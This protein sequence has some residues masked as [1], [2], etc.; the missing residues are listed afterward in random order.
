MSLSIGYR[1]LF[2]VVAGVMISSC[3][4]PIPSNDVQVAEEPSAQPV[5]MQCFELMGSGPTAPDQW[6]AA[7]DA[8][9]AA[10]EATPNVPALHIAVAGAE[11]G[12][13]NDLASL[14]HLEAVVQL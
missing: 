6:T 7:R 9:A 1:T 2:F 4:S 5:L 13:G 3:S 14:E 11:A 12:L 10:L 8:C